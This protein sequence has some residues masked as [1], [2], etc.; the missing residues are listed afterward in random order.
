MTSELCLFR[1]GR[2][3]WNEAGRYQG[4]ADI[5]LDELGR[6]Q[7]DAIAERCKEIAPV[8]IYTSD[9]R[10]CV[11]VAEL[12][13]Q[14][15]DLQAVRDVRLRERNVGKWSGLTRAEIAVQFAGEFQAWNK[16][17][18]RVRPGGGETIGELNARI[19][20]FLESVRSSGVTGAVV[21]VTHAGWIRSVPAV[22]FGNNFSRH[23]VGVPSQGSLTTWHFGDDGSLRLEAYNDRG[24][25]LGIEGSVSEVPAPAIY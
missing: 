16:G 24:H 8:A 1:H 23:N 22:A 13:A 9:L 20:Q 25:L 14:A 19:A 17:D 2:T 12:I 7:A 11:D 3:T 10:R 15:C 21:A 5:E 18:E 6:R 4:W